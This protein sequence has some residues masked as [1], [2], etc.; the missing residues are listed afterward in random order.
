MFNIS[1]SHLKPNNWKQLYTKE[2]VDLCMSKVKIVDFNEQLSVFGSLTVHPKSS[3]YTVGSCN[4]TIEADSD[5]IL[6]MAKS[7]ILNT[8]SKL[9]NPQFLKQQIVDCMLVSRLNQTAM[10]EPEKMVQEFC[11]ACI[12]TVKNQGSVL[13]PTLPTGKIYDLIDCLFRYLGDS[14][15]MNIP[16]YFISSFANQSLA[17]SNIFAEWLNDTLQNYVYAAD[18]P[19]SHAEL[20]RNGFLKIYPSINAKFNDDFHQPCIVFASH[21]S[22]RFGEACHFVELWKNSPANSFIFTEPEFNYLDALAPFQPIYANFYY[23]PID[24]SLNTVQVHKLLKETKHITQLVASSQYRLVKT[25]PNAPGMN[26]QMAKIDPARLGPNTL[27]NF[28]SQNDI[29]K[30]ELKR[31]YENCEI[32]S[33]LAAMIVPIKI[34]IAQMREMSDRNLSNVS[35]ASFNAQLVTK[36]NRHVLKAAPRA[37]PL[38]RRDRVNESNLKK[39]TYG[40]FDLDFFLNSLRQSGI[41]N[42][43][44][45]EKIDDIQESNVESKPAPGKCG[46]YL[47]ELDKANK[48]DV[49][50]ISNQIN[51]ACD[52]DDL[53]VKVKDCLLKCFYTL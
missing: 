21:P 24:T 20:V 18:S 12:F 47:V 31:K 51:V 9:F 45:V 52:N 6:Y 22:L 26:D 38:T 33:D 35:F 43:R 39:Y 49:D 13:I 23:F 53:R 42:F 16:V 5:I 30:L 34:P 17:Y 46:K 37:I 50:T 25:E 29:I 2:D 27:I 48:I 10:C 44:V 19:F 41:V 4:W 36:N 15:L 28:Y 7:S 40:K 1:E 32:E 3:G 11:K 14:N 8:H